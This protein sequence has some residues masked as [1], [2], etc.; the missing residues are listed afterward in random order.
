[1]SKEQKYG[2]F[3]FGDVIARA[4]A[5]EPRLV[6]LNFRRHGSSRQLLRGF[7]ASHGTFFP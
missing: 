4:W 5:P 6:S 3:Q 1:M 7:Q 2:E